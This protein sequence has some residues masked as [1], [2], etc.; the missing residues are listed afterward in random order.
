M[1]I[2]WRC[3]SC[4]AS[5]RA[6]IGVAGLLLPRALHPRFAHEARRPIT[7]R[8]A[9]CC[10]LSLSASRRWNMA[11]FGSV[12]LPKDLP[13]GATVGGPGW[14]LLRRR[15][16]S[17]SSAGGVDGLLAAA[18]DLLLAGRSARSPQL[19]HLPA[20]FRPT[21]LTGFCSAC[22]EWPPLACAHPSTVTPSPTSEGDSPLMIELLMLPEAHLPAALVAPSPRSCPVLRA[23]GPGAPLLAPGL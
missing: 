4:C 8:P 15:Q 12:P 9:R 16:Q 19:Q 14:S 20:G 18:A 1:E 23:L 3:S 13:T 11:L 21:R 17:G 7:D 5:T 22:V 10:P 6:G 2:R